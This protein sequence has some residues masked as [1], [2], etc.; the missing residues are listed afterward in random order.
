MPFEIVVGWVEEARARGLACAVASGRGGAVVRAGIDAT[1]LAHL[2]DT[3]VA[4]ADADRG[5]PT[6]DLSWRRRSGCV[7][8]RSAASWLR[9]RRRD[10]WQ[11]GLRACT[12]STCART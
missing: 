1:G 4:R 12:P 6:P 11:R 8:R 3:V 2:F 10:R 7:S 5:K 9:T